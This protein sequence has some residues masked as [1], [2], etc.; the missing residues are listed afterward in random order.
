MLMCFSFFFFGS[1]LQTNSP[2]LTTF[3]FFS[4]FYYK[5]DSA[6]WWVGMAR[7]C[8]LS[9]PGRRRAPDDSA[10]TNNKTQRAPWL[11]P[12]LVS[13]SVSVSRARSVAASSIRPASVFYFPPT[14]ERRQHPVSAFLER[15]LSVLV[16]GSF[17]RV[18]VAK[19]FSFL[20]PPVLTYFSLILSVRPPP[21][22]TY[23]LWRA[24]C[25]T[26]GTTG[27]RSGSWVRR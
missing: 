14:P 4:F 23:S 22:S 15:L 2:T 25:V 13:R 12:A 11:S 17:I 3:L 26:L 24:R 9:P 21:P 6:L 1:R 8:C 7:S 5:Q 27:R 16:L 18:L 10:H 20:S 19:P